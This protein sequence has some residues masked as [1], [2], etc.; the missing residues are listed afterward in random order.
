MLSGWGTSSQEAVRE[1]KESE[2]RALVVE[3]NALPS[4]DAQ[5][6]W[7]GFQKFPPLVYVCSK[8]GRSRQERL[9]FYSLSQMVKFHEVDTQGN[10]LLRKERVCPECEGGVETEEKE[11]QEDG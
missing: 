7:I 11:E 1:M 8:C 3:Y 6:D 2:A 10:L 5:I 9:S 4:V